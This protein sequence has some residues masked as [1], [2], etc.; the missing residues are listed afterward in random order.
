V[1][2]EIDDKL[3]VRLKQDDLSALGEL[4]E[5]LS[6]KIYNRCFFILKDQGLAEDATQE[7]FLKAFNQVKSLKENSKIEG[8]LN[9]MAYN[10]CID[11]IRKNKKEKTENAQVESN[12]ELVDFV[13]ELDQITE[14]EEYQAELKKELDK[15]SESERL[16]IM[17]YYWE[18]LQVSEISE[19]LNLGESAVKMKLSRTRT[20][21]KDRLTEKGVTHSLEVSILIILNL[22]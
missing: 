18:G 16:I 4:Y 8:W 21:L 15:L 1:Y 13:E 7:I 5:L 22:I 10:Y 12:Q 20:K 9:R 17:L 3:I 2:T 6:K 14:S 11:Q 19:Q